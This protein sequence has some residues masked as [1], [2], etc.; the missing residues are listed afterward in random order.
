MQQP[1]AVLS[2]EKA[3]P[4]V[5][6]SM[7]SSGMRS[8][9]RRAGVCRPRPYPCR[10]RFRPELA[11]LRGLALSSGPGA[12]VRFGR[13]QVDRIVPVLLVVAD[14]VHRADAGA[15]AAVD[16]TLRPDHVR[17]LAR[18]EERDRFRWAGAAAPAAVDAA[19]QGN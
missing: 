12:G 2:T 8:S 4:T 6:G 14:H 13:L 1:A 3:P 15:D 9:P 10:R 5:R 18:Q 16:A 19:F 11:L 17:A 7:Q